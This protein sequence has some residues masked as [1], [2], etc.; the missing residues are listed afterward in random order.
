MPKAL[1][2]LRR[3]P[4]ERYD[5]Q[6]QHPELVKRLEALADEARRDLG[7]DLTGSKGSNIRP[8]GRVRR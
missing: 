2:E 7:D 1:Y 8:A 3:D 5:V 6:A 4:G